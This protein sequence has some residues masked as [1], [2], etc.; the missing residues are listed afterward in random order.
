M[1]DTLGGC[2]HKRTFRNTKKEATATFLEK[3]GMWYLR[4]FF[5][6]LCV[7]AV[8]FLCV[9]VLCPLG[10]TVA[11]EWCMG[12]FRRFLLV[13]GGVAFDSGSSL[14][15]M[16]VVVTITGKTVYTLVAV[17]E[18]RGSDSD[19]SGSG[20]GDCG[21]GVFVLTVVVVDVTA[22][23]GRSGGCSCGG[24]RGGGDGEM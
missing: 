10:L 13:G 3:L 14:V 21:D 22:A 6:C 8:F 2:I 7:C 20:K 11:C 24:C 15:V 19:T 17:K 18:C 9:C 12:C 4:F 5:V 23:V 16:V 1:K